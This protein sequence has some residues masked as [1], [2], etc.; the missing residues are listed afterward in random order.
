MQ[1]VVTVATVAFV[2]GVA[3]GAILAIWLG[4]LTNYPARPD[5]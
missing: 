5:D 4:S 1:P 3:A 2:L